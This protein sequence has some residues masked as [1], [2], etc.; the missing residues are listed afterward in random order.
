MSDNKHRVEN[1]V[2]LTPEGE[3]VTKETTCGVW[4][5]CFKEVS[6]DKVVEQCDGCGEYRRRMYSKIL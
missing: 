1:S 3:V 5:F 6:E 4:Q 2:G